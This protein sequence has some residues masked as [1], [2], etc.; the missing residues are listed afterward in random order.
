MRSVLQDTHGS[1]GKVRGGVIPLWDEKGRVV[2]RGSG[3]TVRSEVCSGVGTG[4]PDLTPSTRLPT[5]LGPDDVHVQ[6]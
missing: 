6:G 3:T 2:L 1:P 5:D 4:T